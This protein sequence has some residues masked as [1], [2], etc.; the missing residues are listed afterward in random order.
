MQALDVGAL[1]TLVGYIC[2]VHVHENI[3]DHSERRNVII[4]GCDDLL[5]K[6]GVRGGG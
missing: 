6:K 4:E 1:L 2:A 5:E 3:A